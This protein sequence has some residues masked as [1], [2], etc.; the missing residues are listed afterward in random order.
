MKARALIASGLFFL[1]W[2][3]GC[4]GPV[5]PENSD[6]AVHAESYLRR[7]AFDMGFNETVLLRWPESAMPLRVHL[8]PP[9]PGLF[10]DPGEI[11]E[12]VESAIFA[13]SDVVAPGLPSFEYVETAREADIRV[14]WVEEPNGDWYVA[15]CAYDHGKLRMRRFGVERLL[16]ASR[17]EQGPELPAQTIHAVVLHE[18]GH[19]LGLGGHSTNAMDVMYGSL[20]RGIDYALSPGDRLT[21]SELYSRPIGKRIAGARR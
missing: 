11:M 6:D 4:A 7:V 3:P 5:Q 16:I 18:M 20:T 1:L 13:W 8:P 21:L 14:A 15:H 9:A 2:A 17:L 12:S 19:A 10:T